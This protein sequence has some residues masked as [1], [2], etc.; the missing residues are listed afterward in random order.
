MENQTASLNKKI[1]F[2]AVLAVI[3][4][5]LLASFLIWPDNP[6]A[7][8]IDPDTGEL[9]ENPAGYG[10]A[11]FPGIVFLIAAILLYFHT[12]QSPLD[13]LLS[14]RRKQLVQ[15]EDAEKRFLSRQMTQESFE[16]F[17]AQRQKE[18]VSIESKIAM[19]TQAPKEENPSDTADV[20]GKNKHKL[21]ELL[22][23]KELVNQS[24]GIAEKKYLKRELSEAEFNELQEKTTSELLE[25]DSEIKALTKDPQV[26]K[27]VAELSR[28]IKKAKP[29]PHPKRKRVWAEGEIQD[30]DEIAEEL[31]DQKLED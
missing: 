17:K 1:I 7:T 31:F 23:K 2:S 21:K 11:L 9:V 28:E 20:A 27:A 14:E 12:S 13:A 19:L 5:G 8:S 26:Q 18:L 15:I 3:G 24:F 22:E 29:N 4:I 30:V 16:K 25:I 6:N 10:W